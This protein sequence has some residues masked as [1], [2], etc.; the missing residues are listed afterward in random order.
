[1]RTQTYFRSCSNGRDL[2]SADHKSHVSIFP[3]SSAQ[4]AHTNV[5]QQMAFS[6][7]GDYNGGVCP[8]SHPVAIV[9]VFTKFFYDTTQ[10]KGFNH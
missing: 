5:M 1:M 6:A 10:V 8:K 7:I 2:N 9:S 3:I 4:L